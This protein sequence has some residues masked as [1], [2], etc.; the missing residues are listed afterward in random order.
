MLGT[1][2]SIDSLIANTCGSFCWIISIKISSTTA[3]VPVP[4]PL[5]LGNILLLDIPD[6]SRPYW[7]PGLITSLCL[8]FQFDHS[9]VLDIPVWSHSC[10]WHPSLITFLCLTSQFDHILPCNLLNPHCG[11]LRRR[12]REKKRLSWRKIAKGIFLANMS[13]SGY[14][15]FDQPPYSDC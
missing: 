6:W 1:P 15:N 14:K 13:I 5:L 10:A 7:Q 9:R 11:K 2:W 4:G 12:F 8:T 3:R